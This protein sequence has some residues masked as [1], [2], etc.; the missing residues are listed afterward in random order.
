MNE[1]RKRSKSRSKSISTS[2]SPIISAQKTEIERL[3][4]KII[5]IKSNCYDLNMVKEY[6]EEYEAKLEK[7]KKEHQKQI[8]NLTQNVSSNCDDCMEN[9]R[10]IKEQVGFLCAFYSEYFL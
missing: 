8:I 5:K 1:K 4:Q 2:E 10:K 9:Q 6:K 3:R 7:I